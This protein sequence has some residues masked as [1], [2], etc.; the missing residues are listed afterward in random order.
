MD[1]SHRPLS[2][3]EQIALSAIAG[4]FTGF[5]IWLYYIVFQFARFVLH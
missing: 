5:V 1:F 4:A 3:L 2:D